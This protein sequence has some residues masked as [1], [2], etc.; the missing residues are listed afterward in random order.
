MSDDPAPQLTLLEELDARQDEALQ[1]LDELNVQVE[2]LIAD[3]MR[4]RASEG[5]AA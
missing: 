1:M 2:R 3:Y 4:V 5:E